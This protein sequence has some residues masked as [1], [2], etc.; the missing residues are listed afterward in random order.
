MAISRAKDNPVLQDFLA[1][2]QAAAHA[3]SGPT[4]VEDLRENVLYEN[5]ALP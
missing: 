1:D 4:L 2:R 3:T 5:S